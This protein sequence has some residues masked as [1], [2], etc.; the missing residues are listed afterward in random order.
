MRKYLMLLASALMLSF[1]A[2]A[3]NLETLDVSKNLMAITCVIMV[4][5]FLKVKSRMA[6]KR[7]SGMK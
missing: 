1:M 7:V 3:Q 5:R 4:T 6:R 2:T